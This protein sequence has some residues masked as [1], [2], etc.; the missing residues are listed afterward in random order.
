MGGVCARVCAHPVEWADVDLNVYVLWKQVF[1]ATSLVVACVSASYFKAV[2]TSGSGPITIRWRPWTCSVLALQKTWKL[3]QTSRT[4]FSVLLFVRM[5]V[6]SPF[7]CSRAAIFLLKKKKEQNLTS[8]MWLC[9]SSCHRSLSCLGLG[10]IF[11]QFITC[12][13]LNH[14]TPWP[15]S[16]T[17]IKTAFLTYILS[18]LHRSFASFASGSVSRVALSLRSAVTGKLCL[19]WG[20]CRTNQSWA[21][22]FLLSKLIK[23]KP[24]K[25]TVLTWA[26]KSTCIELIWRMVFGVR[27]CMRV[28]VCV[29]FFHFSSS[30]SVKANVL[31][32]S[33]FKWPILEATA[34]IM[35]VQTHRRPVWG[36]LGEVS[37][38][39]YFFCV[40]TMQKE[41]FST[42]WASEITSFMAAMDV[43]SKG[44]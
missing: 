4:R 1:S 29:H 36:G 3:K 20:G 33:Y 12:S 13:T 7:L 16:F 27:T 30:L 23:M 14:M 26:H 34:L 25:A 43:M 18:A 15:F 24:L 8:R 6:F 40:Y 38:L 5:L 31:V 41:M 2:Q 21:F 42:E 35:S 19:A 44:Y 11:Y 10:Q 22:C 39:H 17:D 9:V 32:C 37:H 28:F